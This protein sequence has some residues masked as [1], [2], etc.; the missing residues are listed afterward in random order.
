M[1][2]VISLKLTIDGKEALAAINLTDSEIKNLAKTVGQFQNE[3]Q[4]LSEKI[5]SYFANARNLYQ[6]LTETIAFLR[7]TF[8]ASV[9][10]YMEQDAA[11]AKLN[12]ALKQTG[13]YT[14]EN[15]KRLIEYSTEL[16]RTTIYGDELTQTIMAQLIAMGLS[17]EET[18]RAAKQATNLAA[19]MGTDLN[20]AARAIADAFNGNAGMLSRYIKGLDETTIKS[21]NVNE[22]L[23]L[24]E[25]RIGSQAE[26]IGNTAAGQIA[27]FS[28]ALGDLKENAGK[29][30]IDALTPLLKIATEIISSLNAL[31]PAVSGTL[32]VAA[33]LTA[34]LITLRTV[35]LLPSIEAVKALGLSFVSLKSALISSG[36]GAALVGL[37]FALDYYISRKTRALMDIETNVN[38]ARSAA[39][40][41]TDEE[42]RR[43]IKNSEDELKWTEEEIQK[44]RAEYQKSRDVRKRT[45]KDGYEY[46]I[47]YE[48]EKSKQI[49]K[50]IEDLE[51]LQKINLNILNI[52][53][54]ELTLR[55][56]RSDIKK[57][58]KPRLEI[59]TEE[60]ED[61]I[62]PDIKMG[63]P[64]TY[65]KLTAEEELEI[66][67]QKELEK[68]KEYENYN[69]M[70]LALDKEYERRKQE[71][72][73]RLTGDPLTY[74]RLTAEEELEIWKQKELEKIQIYRNY[75]EMKAALDEE[76]LRRKQELLDK[77]A[78]MHIE[79]TQRIL[80]NVKELFGKQTAAYKALAIAQTIIE[81]YKAA[82]AA[83]SPPPVGVGPVFGP[84]LAAAT[85]AAGLA[86]VAKI[87][88]TKVEGFA[89]GG[90]LPPGKIG[91]VEGV[92][93]EIIAPEKTFVEVF[94]QELRPQIYRDFPN[95]N[96]S[97]MEKIIEK[98]D[99][100]QKEIVFRFDGQDWTN[101]TIRLIEAKKRLSIA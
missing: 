80:S 64:L 55:Q 66:W 92:H 65:A 77:E 25:K 74:A 72:E 95:N 47:Y 29:L 57:P 54:E 53:K 33:S 21:K 37:G 1:E 78:E 23:L 89:M 70:K 59:A 17:V 87:I 32:G 50:Q 9:N 15:A 4:N 18:I 8:A 39:M 69:E 61:I 90:K 42:I 12:T 45:D 14:E 88:A 22:I 10:A 73:Q 35:G 40:Q 93:T 91:F 58:G 19:I 63:D 62:L 49:Q 5:T 97:I 30:I 16:Q 2:N 67:K 20:T 56:K 38:E 101:N 71:L 51:R 44:L 41:A 100:W 48:T 46:E 60:L 84:A 31:S 11:A 81:T 13:Q 86:N 99:S 34:A 96:E 27:K 7:G 79:A 98:I 24:L 83:L 85:I 94:K 28:N 26:T 52:Y 76:Y 3:S 82:T 43:M 75:E 6:G 36:I 68:I